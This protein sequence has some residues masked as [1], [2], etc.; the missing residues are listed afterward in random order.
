[1]APDSNPQNRSAS[2]SLDFIHI[3][4]RRLAA[5]KMMPFAEQGETA[6]SCDMSAFAESGKHPLNLSMTGSG[7][8]LLQKSG[9][10]VHRRR[11]SLEMKAM[12]SLPPARAGRR[13]WRW[14]QRLPL[15]L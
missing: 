12:L 14:D 2:Q 11:R 1:M 6:R 9:A 13:L 5:P 7:P 15:N 10:E 8:I 4:A 3:S